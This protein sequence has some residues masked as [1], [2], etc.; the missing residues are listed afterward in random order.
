MTIIHFFSLHWF[1]FSSFKGLPNAFCL[2]FFSSVSKAVMG[3]TSS[4]A[5]PSKHTKNTLV[6]LMNSLSS[7]VGENEKKM[8][9]VSRTSLIHK[10]YSKLGSEPSILTSIIWMAFNVFWFMCMVMY[11]DISACNLRIIL[12]QHKQFFL[13]LFKGTYMIQIMSTIYKITWSEF[14]FHSHKNM[15]ISLVISNT[16]SP[17]WP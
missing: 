2:Y 11:T 13:Q 7:N 1:E 15:K 10:K 6:H 9:H 12:P 3:W 4:K 8:C 5:F 17:R 14:T 16:S